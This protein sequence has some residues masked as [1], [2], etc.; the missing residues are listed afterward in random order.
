M[1]QLG[2]MLETEMKDTNAIEQER[3]RRGAKLAAEMRESLEPRT[4]AETAAA[5]VAGMPD[6]NKGK[7]AAEGGPL[8]PPV[9]PLP[10]KPKG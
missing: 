7:R 3:Q 9:R 2:M 10:E 8:D 4:A 1:R 6:V 5:F